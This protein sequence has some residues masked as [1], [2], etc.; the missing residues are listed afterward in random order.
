MLNDLLTSMMKKQLAMQLEKQFEGVFDKMNSMVDTDGVLSQS[1]INEIVDLMNGASAGAQQIAEAYYDLM[2]EMGL[3]TDSDEEGSKGGFESMSQDTADELNARFTALQITGA[4]M[5][6]T[7]QTMSQAIIEL[8][9]SDKLKMTIL[10][11]LQENIIMGVQTAQNQLDELRI[12]AD[13]TGMLNETNRRLK[14]IE[15]HTAKL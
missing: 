15:Q 10:Q 3:L 9:V 8:N 4:N 2:D 12:I 7:M 11:T 13:N 5:D 6:A 14:A 1:E